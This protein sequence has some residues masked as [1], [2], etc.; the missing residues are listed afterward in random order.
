MDDFWDKYVFVLRIG[1]LSIYFENNPAK[2]PGMGKRAHNQGTKLVSFLS[3]LLFRPG[4]D[5]LFKLSDLN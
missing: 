3:K 5:F 1:F 2:S 4:L